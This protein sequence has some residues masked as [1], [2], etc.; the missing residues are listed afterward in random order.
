MPEKG[1]ERFTPANLHLDKPCS[2]REGDYVRYSDHQARLQE[3]E[4]ERDR[5]YEAVVELESDALRQ[6]D[7]AEQAE[8]QLHAL[9]GV[10]ERADDF[11][12]YVTDWEGDDGDLDD[13]RE[14]LRSEL[15]AAG[16]ERAA[17]EDS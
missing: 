2:D 16:T 12:S 13:T 9:R 14:A 15:P 7:R 5:A 8:S 17:G 3:V 1:I 11:L 4:A 10:L 6:K